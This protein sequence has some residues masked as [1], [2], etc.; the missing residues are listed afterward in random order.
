MTTVKTGISL[1]ETALIRADSLAKRLKTS[2]SKVVAQAIDE[3]WTREENRRL[4]AQ[5]NATY[6]NAPSTLEENGWLREAKKVHARRISR[7]AA[8]W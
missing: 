1:E 7:E 2:S 3:L 5:L 8:E 6:E 4:L